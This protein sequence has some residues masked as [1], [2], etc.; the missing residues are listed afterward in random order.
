LCWD[1][2]SRS[3]KTSRSRA[4]PPTSWGASTKSRR[5]RGPRHG[6]R[7]AARVVPRRPEPWPLPELPEVLA[8]LG[9][10]VM[11]AASAPTEGDFR[12]KALDDPQRWATRTTGEASSTVAGR[13]NQRSA[14]VDGRRQATRFPP[15]RPPSDRTSPPRHRINY[16]CSSG[17]ASRTRPWAHGLLTPCCR[18]LSRA[19]FRLMRFAPPS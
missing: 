4:C 1:G 13:R 17:S 5:P 2:G 6:G 12:V 3:L 19:R 16:G 10:P 18:K 7:R 15:A 11:A 14:Y 8:G 9:L